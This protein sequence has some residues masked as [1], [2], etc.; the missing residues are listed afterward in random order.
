MIL[1]NDSGLYRYRLGDVIRVERMEDGVPIF[2]FAYRESQTCSLAGERLTEQ[3]VFGAVQA[4]QEETGIDIGDFCI[5]P[6]EEGRRYTV[7]LE[8]SG[9]PGNQELLYRTGKQRLENILEEALEAAC[10]GYREAAERKELL[11][12]RALCLQPQTH[13]L[14]RDVERYRKKTAPDQ[15]KPVRVLD[16]PVKEKFFFS[17]A[18][19][20]LHGVQELDE[21][22]DRYRQGIG[23]KNR[24]QDGVN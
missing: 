8:P 3:D 24:R 18:D 4:L 14:Y 23:K 16:N 20:R 21:Y 13:L 1:T 22:R 9:L 11:P 17:M 5:W 2:T 6:D 10:A 7:Q 19:R 12:A 15:I